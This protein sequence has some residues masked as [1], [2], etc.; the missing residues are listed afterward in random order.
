M[1]ETNDIEFRKVQ[2]IM[3]EQSVGITLPKKYAVGLGIGKG[4]FVRIHRETNKIV[5][6]KVE[7]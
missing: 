6:E 5:I 2:G 3:K 4:D 7:R 1:K